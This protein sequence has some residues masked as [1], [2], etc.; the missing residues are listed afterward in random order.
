MLKYPIGIQSFQELIEGKY[1][2]VD[3]TPDIYQ[4]L[5]GKYYF[6]SRPRRF[7]KSLLLS[8]LK[9]LFEGKRHLFDGLWIQDKIEWS[10]HP[11]V[12]ISFTEV[13]FK[14]I[15]LEKALHQVL[16][17]HAL[18]YGI[19]LLDTSVAFKYQELIRQLF[20]KF[21]KKV[22][23]LIDEYDTPII[24]N[25]PDNMAQA[26]EN[27]ELLKP[28]YSIMKNEDDHIQ[29]LIITGIS[30]F[31]KVSIFSALNN[32]NDISTDEQYA[33]ICGWKQEELQQ[34]FGDR[35]KDIAK[36]QNLTDISCLE[37]VKRLY[38]GFCFS[39]RATTFVYNPF[40]M[41]L[42]LSKGVFDNYWFQTGTPTFLAKM[43]KNDYQYNLEEMILPDS[44]LTSYDLERLDYRAILFQTGYITIK[45]KIEDGIYLMG[46]PNEEV[47]ASM[48][49]FLLSEYL[50]INRSEGDVKLFTLRN[51]L[52]NGD[53]KGV[54][55]HIDQLFATI[56]ADL[57]KQNYENFY[58]AIIF[59]TFHLLGLKMQ[60]EVQHRLGVIDAI[61]ENDNFVYVFEF[62]VNKSAQSAL[63]Q[64]KDNQYHV[65]YLNKGKKVFLI[66]VKFSDKK[67][68]VDV[69]KHEIM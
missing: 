60:A 3:K 4:L 15:G 11:I 35:I 28:F 59:M 56:P 22:V 23:I 2:Y 44:V 45:K 8:T 52:N 26:K 62:K 12:H 13:D 49:N 18:N 19:E 33:S 40:S 25:L 32:L 37:Q 14:Y 24:D 43:L 1:V 16:D 42:F 51:M 66:G 29:F 21:N 65:P 38:N 54:M 67:R 50:D 27:R 39:K 58:H 53:V 5:Q 68:G 61:V 64:I 46:Y 36:E 55:Q 6:L 69:W 47:K 48:L 34:H 31:T 63:K 7:G 41:L 20:K 9:A 57:F 10:A 17:R 30:K